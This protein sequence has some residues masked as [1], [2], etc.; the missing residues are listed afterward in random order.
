MALGGMVACVGAGS[1][2]LGG[3]AEIDPNIYFGT[4]MCLI[5]TLLIASIW[6]NRE[7]EPEII[8]H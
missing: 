6:M 5:C 4:Y 3:G 8:L 2:E 7:L 1:I